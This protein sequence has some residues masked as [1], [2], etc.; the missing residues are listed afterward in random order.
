M[1]LFAQL[2]GVCVV[3]PDAAAVD[4]ACEVFCRARRRDWDRALVE[5][6]GHRLAPLVALAVR[7]SGLA[8]GMPRAVVADLDESFRRTLFANTLQLNLLRDLLA[9]FE[10]AGIRPTVMKGL[11]VAARYYP[12]LGARPMV[13]ID[14]CVDA[15]E[16]LA[17]QRV[18]GDRGFERSAPWRSFLH[19][20]REFAVDLH[21][22]PPSFLATAR[23]DPTVPFELDGRADVWEPHAMLLHLLAHMEKHTRVVG[24]SLLWV[25]DV[26]RLVRAESSSL[27]LDRLRALSDD[28]LISD[29]QL[30]ASTGGD[31]IMVRGAPRHV[32]GY[33]K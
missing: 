24:V 7:R 19:P 1:T 32:V 25:V 33:L 6:H 18:L 11:A 16:N 3:E 22:E 30:G 27:S 23:D 8:K 15:S 17:A 28:L 13:D 5:L 21:A 2:L 4:A 14:L 10:R 12:D 31:Q 20:D 9:S 29:P 26:L